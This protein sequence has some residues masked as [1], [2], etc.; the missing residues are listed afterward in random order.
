MRFMSAIPFLVARRLGGR[1]Q[2]R[3]LSAARK[4]AHAR[5]QQTIKPDAIRA[6]L[7]ARLQRAAQGGLRREWPAP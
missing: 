7:P 4:L 2:G 3:R 1:R 6:R 5:R